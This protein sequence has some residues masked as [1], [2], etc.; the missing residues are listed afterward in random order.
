VGDESARLLKTPV[1][2]AAGPSAATQLTHEYKL[3]RDL[4]VAGCDA[5]LPKPIKAER[6]LDLLET[7]LELTWVYAKPEGEAETT[8]GPLVPPPVEELDIL[9]DLARRGN[10]RAIQE[11]VAHIETLGEQYVPFAR[12]LHELAE[13]FEERELM[14][15]VEQHMER[16]R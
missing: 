3:C 11:R 12:K 16:Y 10:L 1:V 9:L 5:F 4:D 2:D 7:H 14:A 13:G 8:A 15:L 6:L